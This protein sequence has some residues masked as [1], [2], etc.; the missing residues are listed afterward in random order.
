[1]K[2]KDSLTE[3]S[4]GYKIL[5]LPDENSTV[6]YVVLG[7]IVPACVGLLA[8]GVLYFKQL[9]DKKEEEEGPPNGR[10]SMMAGLTANKSRPLYT[11]ILLMIATLAFVFGIA[12]G[13][14]YA[15]AKNHPDWKYTEL[16]NPMQD[17]YLAGGSSVVGTSPQTLLT[18]MEFL[19]YVGFV[20]WM[21]VV[22][23][24]LGLEIFVWH[25]F[26]E[27]NVS[28]LFTTMIIFVC[29]MPSQTILDSILGILLLF[30][31]FGMIQGME[32]GSLLR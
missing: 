6:F 26:L 4:D 19:V 5:Y 17:S 7:L 9:K 1:M 14:N 30:Y 31:R 10:V 13:I 23:A 24:G 16:S 28:C 25:H 21:T 8:F 12:G 2:S 20:T 22:V 32:C 29:M 3:T 11:I 27:G 18:D 15:V